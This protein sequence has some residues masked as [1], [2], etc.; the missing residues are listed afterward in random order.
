MDLQPN[1]IGTTI[2]Y[3]YG[4][5]YL[6][7]TDFHDGHCEIE[8]HRCV[9]EQIYHSCDMKDLGDARMTFEELVQGEVRS[10]ILM[11]NGTPAGGNNG[12]SLLD[13]LRAS[14]RTLIT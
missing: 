4:H 1:R 7:L 6:S 10:R 9:P 3:K 2:E 14:E 8:I 11:A 5:Y 12:S 13:H